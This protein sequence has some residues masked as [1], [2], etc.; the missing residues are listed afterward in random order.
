MAKRVFDSEGH[1]KPMDIWL[2]IN[3]DKYAD[4][5]LWGT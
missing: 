4:I 3:I 1:E 2:C 5:V